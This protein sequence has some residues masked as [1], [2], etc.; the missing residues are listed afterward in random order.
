[1]DVFIDPGKRLSIGFTDSVLNLER[2]VGF[3]RVIGG[4][5]SLKNIRIRWG[6]AGNGG[7]RG[8]SIIPK[9]RRYFRSA[10]DIDRRRP[11]PVIFW[12]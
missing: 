9:I 6:G 1:M 12:C 7:M 10:T 8:A 11:L 4:R 5:D 2:H 3:I